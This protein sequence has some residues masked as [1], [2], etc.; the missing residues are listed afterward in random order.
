MMISKQ[1]IFVKV[2]PTD[3]HLVGQKHLTIWKLIQKIIQDIGIDK[4]RQL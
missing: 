4:V 3:F 2:G 1:T